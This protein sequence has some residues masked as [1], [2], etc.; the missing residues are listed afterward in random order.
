MI[1]I[2]FAVLN[3]T[4]DVKLKPNHAVVRNAAAKTIVAK[5]PMNNV[6]AR[7]IVLVKNLVVVEITVNAKIVLK[8]NVA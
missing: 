2:V 5:A 8:R 7:R 3:A 1:I 4:A 6:Y